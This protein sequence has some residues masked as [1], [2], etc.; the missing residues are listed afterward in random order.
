MARNMQNNA[1]ARIRG[2][3]STRMLEAGSGRA[4]VLPGLGA[5]DVLLLDTQCEESEVCA[6]TLESVLESDTAASARAIVLQETLSAETDELLEAASALPLVAPVRFQAC[7]HV[8]SAFELLMLLCTRGFQC[9]VC[10][11]GSGNAV[12]LEGALPAH[13]PLPPVVWR[14][15]CTLGS[16]VRK[17]RVH[18]AMLEDEAGI[19]QMQALEVAVVQHMPVLGLLDMCSFGITVAGFMSSISTG[20]NTP[21]I[22]RM[23]YRI[24]LRVLQ[25]NTRDTEHVELQA[26]RCRMLSKF[27]N[28]SK[29]YTVRVDM[30][31]TGSD[32]DEYPVL[33]GEPMQ[34]VQH[35]PQAQR[36]DSISDHFSDSTSERM[37][38]IEYK[39]CQYSGKHIVNS[40]KMR[41]QAATVRNLLTLLVEQTFVH[42]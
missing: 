21:N 18:E 22:P 34:C 14:V 17:R 19:M 11:G 15:L 36:T 1:D 39:A 13:A 8:F 32:G 38:T 42:F 23:V 26:G 33:V 24:P 35:R 2:H 6:L 31:L 10:R 29:W 20:R 7:G 16:I 3:G 37:L 5:E 41:I 12:C 28:T 30:L 40:I 27:L 9:P 25:A 4:C